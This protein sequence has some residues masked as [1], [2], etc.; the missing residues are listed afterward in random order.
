MQQVASLDELLHDEQAPW[1]MFIILVIFAYAI[2]RCDVSVGKNEQ[3]FSIMRAEIGRIAYGWD[4]LV[5]ILASLIKRRQSLRL[6]SIFFFST[7]GDD[8]HGPYNY[9]SGGGAH[10]RMR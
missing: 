2:A 6:F 7:C 1:V 5:I 9:G 3:R 4:I 8:D 10:Y